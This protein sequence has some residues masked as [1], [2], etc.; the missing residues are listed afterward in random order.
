MTNYFSMCDIE[1]ARTQINARTKLGLPISQ[2]LH[3]VA[4]ASVA[5]R[6]A[7]RNGKTNLMALP[8][9]DVEEV[10]F[11]ADIE[12]DGPI[13]GPYSMSSLGL[14]A[15]AYRTKT[16]KH[17]RLDLDDERHCFYAELKPISD[18]FIPEAAAVAGLDRSMLI[19]DGLE[20]V[21]AMTDLS[22][23]IQTVTEAYGGFARPVFV[24]YPLGFDWMFVYW[25][26]MNYSKDG[27]PFG[28]SSHLDIKTLFAQKSG[29]PI[30]SIGK[31]SIPKTLKS[32]RKH[33]HNALD[34]AREQ[35]DLFNNIVEWE[36]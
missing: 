5:T 33:T 34:D 24:G 16:G 18:N 13:P 27:S 25:Y 22:R 30:R 1:D 7:G 28:H 19:T 32:K 8:Y 3:D 14:V 31:R 12:S 15:C 17:V 21:K 9:D 2:E 6:Q 26:L 11:S 10:Y 36:I 4:N 35:A 29:K 20:P 23:M